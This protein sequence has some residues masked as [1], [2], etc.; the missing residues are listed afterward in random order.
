MI[1]CCLFVH[2]G[3]FYKFH[4]FLFRELLRKI[5]FFYLLSNGSFLHSCLILLMFV[6]EILLVLFRV[7]IETCYYLFNFVILSVFFR[8]RFATL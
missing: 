4:I 2:M 8:S 1:V 3:Q 6:F 5:Y 7:I